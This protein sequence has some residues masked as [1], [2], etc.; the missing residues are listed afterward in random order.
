M[1]KVSTHTK[2]VTEPRLTTLRR[3]VIDTI[4]EAGHDL[5]DQEREILK[6]GITNKY[7]GDF[8]LYARNENGKIELE[9][10]FSI[11]WKRH[12]IEVKTTPNIQLNKQAFN[13]A[14]LLRTL[15]EWAKLFAEEVV[16]C[17][18]TTELCYGYASNVNTQEARQVLGLKPMTEEELAW[19]GEYGEAT[20]SNKQI[21]E[22]S[23]RLRTLK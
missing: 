4:S 9:L 19:A 1:A 16:D 5:T 20:F 15:F 6:K 14:G 23:A 21:P 8:T 18:L 7:L 11:D 2:T 22:L 10:S 13:S 3:Q 12:E 17:N